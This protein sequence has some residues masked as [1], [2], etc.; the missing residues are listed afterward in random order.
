MRISLKTGLAAAVMAGSTIVAVA[1]SQA[2][3]FGVSIGVPGFGFSYNTGG[4]CDRWGCPS[5]YWGY[6]IYYGPVYYGG[7][8]YRGPLYYR[9]NGGSYWYWLHGGWHQDEWRGERPDWARNYYYGPAMGLDW[10]R[11]HGFAVRDEDWGR[12]ND[13]SRTHSWDRDHWDWVRDHDWR[14][15][16]WGND[17]EHDGDRRDGDDRDNHDH[18][19]HQ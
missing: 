14:N 8:W 19:N 3:S 16:R 9:F 1:P 11:S 17:H 5:S 12:W 18:D 15:D 7:T 2:A 6:P 10:Y 4:Y 13:W